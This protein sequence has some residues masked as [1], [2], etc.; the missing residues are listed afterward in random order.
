LA[1]D[2]DEDGSMEDPSSYQY[3]IQRLPFAL[4]WNK[5]EDEGIGGG[6]GRMTYS[7]NG[8]RHA[9]L[10]GYSLGE[11]APDVGTL[12]LFSAIL[13]PASLLAFRRAVRKA[14]MEGTLVH[15]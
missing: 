7:L 15:Y 5:F 13:L 14:K 11:L 4:F 12:V 8:M 3:Q 1:I 6:L 2:G 10:Q 9:L